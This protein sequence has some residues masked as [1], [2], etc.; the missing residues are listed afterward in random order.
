MKITTE[1][2][3][4]PIRRKNVVN[5]QSFGLRGTSKF[6]FPGREKLTC[7]M[8]LIPFPSCLV[9]IVDFEYRNQAPRVR[10]NAQ[11]AINPMCMNLTT[12]GMVGPY[13]S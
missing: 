4:K 8:T 7:G 3:M 5:S 6:G 1:L 2:R 9:K 11:E 13:F 10:L 12:V